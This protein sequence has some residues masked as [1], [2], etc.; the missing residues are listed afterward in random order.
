MNPDKKFDRDMWTILQ[1][2]REHELYWLSRANTWFSS[3]DSRIQLSTDRWLIESQILTRLQEW[4]GIKNLTYE[5]QF[6][7]FQI[8]PK[9]RRIYR[10]YS[11]KFWIKGVLLYLKNNARLILVGFLA[12]LKILK[13]ILR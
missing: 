8:T 4:G 5:S 3:V 10:K 6:A 11:I 1:K 13:G 7:V 9:F 12:F 2:I